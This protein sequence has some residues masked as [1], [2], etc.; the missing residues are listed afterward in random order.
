MADSLFNLGIHYQDTQ[1]YQPSLVLFERSQ[2]LY[3]QIGD[4]KKVGD[5]FNCKAITYY[6]ISDFSKAVV[7]FEDGAEIFKKIHYKKGVAST[8]NNVGNIYNSQGNYAKALAYFQQATLI[9]KEIGDIENWAAATNNV[10]LIYGKVKDYSNAMKYFTQ[11]YAVFKKENKQER[12]AQ[13]QDAIGNIYVKLGK[14]DKAFQSFNESLQIADRRQDKQL[15]IMAL[16]S[17]GDLFNEQSAYARALPYYT[18]CLTYANQIGSLH[19]QA[20]AQI[21][22]GTI[23]Y[24]LGKSKDAVKKCRNGLQLAEKVGSVSMKKRGCDCLYQS[25]KAFGNT[26]QALYYFEQANTLEDSLN[27]SETANRVM[28]IEFQKQQLVDSIAYVQKEHIIQLKHKEEVERQEK[29]RNMSILSLG[30]ILLVAVGLW[31]QL[32]YVKKSRAALKVEKDR[33]EALLLNILPEEIA[34]ELKEKGHVDA[35]VFNL[36]SIL[37]TD[38]KSF[39]QTAEQMSPQSLVEEIHTCFKAFD[40]IVEKYQIEKIKTIGDAFMAVGGLSYTDDRSLKNI[41][42]AGLEMQEFMVK[43]AVEKRVEGYPAFEMRLGIHTGP[44]VAGIVGVKKFQYDVW[45]D[46]VNTASRMESS[47]MVGKVNIS[48]TLYEFIKQEEC[49]SFEYRGQ[50]HAKGKGKMGM[51]FVKKSNVVQLVA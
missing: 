14:Y 37:F 7:A 46:T 39:T 20:E 21:A 51:Y 30:F 16:N 1:V 15:Q 26:G 45:G 3:R 27:L 28:N 48:E 41:V 50:V 36:V 34:E 33:S 32:N 24:R 23:M 44:I 38:F 5:C 8:L 18:R 43:R 40:L 42:L 11:A 47:G 4:W 31:A 9:F 35:R 13:T 49:F 12:I 2:K 10:G 6:Y 25:Y 19:S 22:I 17:L 29:Q